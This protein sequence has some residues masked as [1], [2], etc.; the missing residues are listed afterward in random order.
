MKDKPIDLRDYLFSIIYSIDIP[1]GVRLK[2]YTPP[3]YRVKGWKCTESIDGT[4]KD[5]AEYGY[6]DEESKNGGFQWTLGKHRK[7]CAVL[8]FVDFCE[9][10]YMLDLVVEKC[11]TM[12][13]LG[14]PGC[15]YGISPAVPFRIPDERDTITCCYVTPIPPEMHSPKDAGTPILEGMDE[16]EVHLAT[17]PD[18]DDE[19]EPAMWEWFDDGKW[20]A[21]RCA[22]ALD[23]E[24]A[25]IGDLG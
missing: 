15:G 6:L 11:H 12:G 4:K 21:E 19:I 22:E 20:S 10:I 8:N 3:K 13:S 1:K 24:V 23:E 16:K 2:Q 18:F 9:F 14:A 7:H 5:P 17:M 25:N